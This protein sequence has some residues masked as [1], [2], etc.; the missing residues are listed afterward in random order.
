MKKIVRAVCISIFFIIMMC[1]LGCTGYSL[2]SEDMAEKRSLGESVIV[3]Y[4]YKLL[5]YE[6][7]PYQLEVTPHDIVRLEFENGKVIDCVEIEFAVLSTDDNKPAEYTQC[8]V[9]VDLLT[10]DLREVS[11]SSWYCDTRGTQVNIHN[12]T[13]ELDFPKT[14]YIP[15]DKGIENSGLH[16]ITISDRTGFYSRSGSTYWYELT[17]TDDMHLS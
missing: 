6:K 17:R 11:Y 2:E 15:L 7:G 4:S 12:E 14:Y 10:E 3:D 16:W 8:T 1:L 9:V 13:L 5:L